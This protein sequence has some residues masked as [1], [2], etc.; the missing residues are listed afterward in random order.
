[1]HRSKIPGSN[2]DCNNYKLLRNIHNSY[3]SACTNLYLYEQYKR[4]PTFPHF[5]QALFLFLSHLNQCEV[6]NYCVFYF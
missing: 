3:H 1:M 6:E 5:S 4:N 2:D